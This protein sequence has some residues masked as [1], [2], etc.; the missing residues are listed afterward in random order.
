MENIKRI[1]AAPPQNMTRVLC[2]SNDGKFSFYYYK[3]G[4]YQD[5]Q[6]YNWY[7]P[8]HFRNYWT[9]GEVRTVFSMPITS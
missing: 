1:K 7:P 6:S 5:E 8:N 4:M 3:D 2:E 9:I